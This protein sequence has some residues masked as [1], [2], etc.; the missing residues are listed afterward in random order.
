MSSPRYIGFDTLSLHAG[1][2]PDPTT[3]SRAAPIYQTTSYVF[4]DSDFAASL[5]DIGRTGHVYSRISNP[6]VG[7]VEER[8]A[9]L[10]GG[11]GA[12][13]TASGMSAIHLAI[14]TLAGSGN[15]I[16]ASSA[17]YGGTQ[18]LFAYTLPRFGITTTFVDPHDVD[19][20]ARAITP[21]TRLVYGETIGNPCG[22]ILDLPAV[23]AVAH[24]ADV[25]LV[26]DATLSTPCLMKP[27]EWDADIVVHSLTKFIGGH[28]VAVGGVVIDSGRF[29]WQKSGKFPQLTEAYE[30]FH[31]IS[32]TDDFG[33]AAFN[34][35]ARVEGLR[36][37]G[38]AMSP[39]NAFYFLQGLETLPLRMRRHVDNARAIAEYLSTHKAVEAVTYAGLPGHDDYAL[40]QRLMP[41]GCGAVFSFDIKG[42]REAGRRFID[43]L[44]LFSHL[45]NVGDAKSL[46][47]HPATTTHHRMD[48]AALR[49]AGISEGLVRLSIGL[50]DPQDL[51]DDLGRALHR[52]QK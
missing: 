7:V 4:E 5:F 48:A 14:A 3:G 32:F 36:D 38:A 34:A 50:E 6:T 35:R 25:P 49:D 20:F 29:D 1:Q 12:V 8:M 28:G 26:I 41:D 43:A 51:I 39:A 52:S 16:V 18:N 21:A 19:A 37:F 42:G 17:L 13:A 10:E 30:G 23:A 33:P 24:A 46:V 45:A 15:H 44:E 27:F 47:I 11:V 22:E 31:G 9:A 40:G 2:R